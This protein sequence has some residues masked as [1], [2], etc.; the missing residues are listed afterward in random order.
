MEPT[1]VQRHGF[2][3]VGRI[4]TPTP[5]A[6]G[7]INTYAILPPPGS[8]QLV[9][10]DTGVKSATAWAALESGLKEFGFAV[11]DIRLVLL[12]HAHPDHYGQAARIQRAAGCPVWIHEDAGESFK[13]YGP[14]RPERAEVVSF[15]FTRWGVPREHLPTRMGPP[16][17]Q[18]YVESLTPD[19]YLRDGDVVQIEGYDLEVIH[20][21]GHC[22]EEVVFWQPEH[23]ELLSGDHLLPDITPVALLDVPATRSAARSPALIRYNESLTRVERLPARR[24]FPSHGDVILNHRKLIA[25]YRLHQEKRKKR[26]LRYLQDGGL[27]PCELG[28]RMFARVWRDQLHLVLSEV[29]G[30]LDVLESDGAV[31]SFER[32]GVV[33]YRARRRPGED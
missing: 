29:I 18:S 23:R 30:H 26:M 27:S 2:G 6:V 32:D 33:R 10:V 14:I 3:R 28:Q 4:P 22:P 31:E 19:R 13:R 25:G 11:E 7:D 9:L 1:Y 8:D 16:D 17:A 20:T 5:F 24:A 12:T 15:H 21:P